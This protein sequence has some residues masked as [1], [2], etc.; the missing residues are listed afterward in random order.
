MQIYIFGINYLLIVHINNVLQSVFL[1]DEKKSFLKFIANVTFFLDRPSFSVVIEGR[2]RGQACRL[3]KSGT[4]PAQY[5]TYR[6]IIAYY[7]KSL[8]Y[9]IPWQSFSVYYMKGIWKYSRLWFPS[10]FVICLFMN[11]SISIVCILMINND[12]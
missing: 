10:I 2:K 1:F 3:M 9:F 11:L 5:S 8:H 12:V 7:E 4:L 6:L